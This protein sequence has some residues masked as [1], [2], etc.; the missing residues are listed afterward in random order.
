MHCPELDRGSPPVSFA[1][2]AGYLTE[3]EAMADFRSSA[4]ETALRAVCPALAGGKATDGKTRI[5]DL[6]PTE[7]HQRTPLYIGSGPMVDA[8]MKG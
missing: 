8:A 1:Q 2:E 5:L 4:A 6:K 3:D 7:L